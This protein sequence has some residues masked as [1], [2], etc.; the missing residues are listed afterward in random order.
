MGCQH[1][2]R[3]QRVIPANRVEQC[4]SVH[5]A[6]L[7]IGDD[8]LRMLAVQQRERTLA[9]VRRNDAVALF[10]QQNAQQPEQC[11]V[12]IDDEDGRSRGVVH[13]RWWKSTPQRH[14]QCGCW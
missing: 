3:Q 12:V 8:E 4:E 9:A 11:R 7:E 6:H 13:I 14:P 5:A 1:D 2:D 10:P